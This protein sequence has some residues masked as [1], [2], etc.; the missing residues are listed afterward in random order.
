[1]AI[2]QQ[3]F[4][5]SGMTCASCAN[6]VE[7]KL[8]A[9]Q[10]VE[11]AVVNFADESVGLKYDSEITSPDK[12][13]TS[14]QQIGYGL[15]TA[16]KD[17]SALKRTALVT[18]KN[19]MWLA[20]AL[21]AP[22]VVLAMV[23][24]S[25]LPHSHY[26]EM[27][28]SLGAMLFPGRQFYVNALKRAKFGQANM[29]TLV[30][31]ST[32]VAFVYSAFNTFYPEWLTE[33]GLS[34]AVYFESVVVIIAFILVGKYLEERAKHQS[35]QALRELMQLQ[36]KEVTAIRNG[37]ETRIL[38]EDVL[39]FDRLVIKAGASI[40]V[41]GKVIKGHSFVNESTITG[42][43]VPTEK[44]KGAYLFAGT[45]NQNG[46]LLMLAEKLG[47]ETQ[48]GR[49]VEA[50]RNAQGSKAPAQKL[51]DSISRV[52]V[53]SVIG[54]AIVT[55]AVWL[56]LGGMAYFS[57]ALSAA[58]A[59]LIIACPCALGLATP[60]ALMVG[61]GKAAKLGILVKDATQLERL[62]KVST[63]VMDKTGT[64]TV[65]KPSVQKTTWFSED[66]HLKELLLAIESRSD[67]PLAEAICDDLTATGISEKSSINHH[68]TVPGKGVKAEFN[69]KA[70]YVGKSGWLRELVNLSEPESAALDAAEESGSTLVCFFSDDAVLALLEISDAVKND[71]H[72]AIN[73]VKGLGIGVHLLTGDHERAAQQVAQ[74]LGIAHVK[75]NVLPSEKADYIIHLQVAGETVGMAGDGINDAEALATADISLAMGK[76]SDIAMDVAGI[77]LLGGK[78]HLLPQAIS[79]S[80]NT[81]KIIRQNLFWAFAYNVVCIP[82]AAGVLYP[83]TGF[84]LNPMIAGAAMALS[85]VTVVLNS[86]RLK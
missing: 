15:Q 70:F 45:I 40:P 86:L 83:L 75:A 76:G 52:F 20:L 66:A 38:L 44:Q 58:T 34:V 26:I 22:V 82:I 9:D 3:R 46:Q 71:A 62:N 55:F 74:T 53:P 48:L 79:L 16:E 60:T 27:A 12:L 49:I 73:E 59:V 72:L 4:G 17:E 64:L 80:K 23:F 24:M 21:A 10:G 63:W 30:A 50:V 85:S 39:L 28:L 6:S 1:M 33:Q 35:G 18:A 67:H 37:E 5:V 19:H 65:G 11:Q 13:K 2:V 84:L 61:L 69:G 42:E 8:N 77:T 7:Q 14:L 29:D 41:D 32:A 51:A 54:V 25:Q 78:L 47:E 57:Q 43:P 31:L 36:P 81:V 56:W 68:L